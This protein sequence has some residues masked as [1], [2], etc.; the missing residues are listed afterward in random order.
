M[1]LTPPE[2]RM[3]PDDLAIRSNKRRRLEAL[4]LA[5]RYR[6]VTKVTRAEETFTPPSWGL[7]VTFGEKLE[8]G[9]LCHGRFFFGERA[10]GRAC[11]PTRSI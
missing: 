1:R 2:W 3:K 11:T 10:Q 4:A 9:F 5:R 8:M 6:A 7:F